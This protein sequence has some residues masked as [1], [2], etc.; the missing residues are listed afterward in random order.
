MI[1]YYLPIVCIVST[2]VLYQI[3]A[4]NV[5]PE[6]SPMA[7]LVVTYLVAAA[8]SFVAFIVVPHESNFI[9]Q[10]KNITWAP[11]LLGLSIVGM[12]IGYIIVYR[13]G[14]N[15]SLASLVASIGQAVLLIM[16]GLLIYKEYIGAHQVIGIA[17]CIAGL[18]F[19]NWK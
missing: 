5:P 8:V 16:V 14:W 17:L 18:I 12:E 2:A 11:V 7:V 1:Q 10:M 15:I 19:I 4:K 3:C 13:V 6:A 9:A